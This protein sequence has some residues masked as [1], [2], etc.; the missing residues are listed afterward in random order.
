MLQAMMD[1]YFFDNA[2]QQTVLFRFLF[3]YNLDCMNFSTVYFP[4]LVN[5]AVSSA[6]D[7][8]DKIIICKTRNI[9]HKSKRRCWP[10]RTFNSFGFRKVSWCN[11]SGGRN[12]ARNTQSRDTR[13]V[14]AGSIYQGEGD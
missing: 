5:Y 8:I 9:I 11:F 12:F 7:D 4:S 10:T 2:L 14:K 1:L 3:R 6:P 13:H